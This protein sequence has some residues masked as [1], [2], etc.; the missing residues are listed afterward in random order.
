MSEHSLTNH[1]RI[2]SLTSSVT[3]PILSCMTTTT[4]QAIETLTAQLKTERNLATRRAIQNELFRL[5]DALHDE[6]QQEAADL[7][8]W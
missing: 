6:V 7:Y 8:G 4:T 2:G 5:E 1:V 3:S